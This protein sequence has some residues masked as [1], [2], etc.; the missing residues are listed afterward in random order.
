MNTASSPNISDVGGDV[1]SNNAG[2]SANDSD[3]AD[4]IE[5]YEV[6]WKVQ[7]TASKGWFK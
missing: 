7:P 3:T 4:V 5:G 6:E 2:V 1:I